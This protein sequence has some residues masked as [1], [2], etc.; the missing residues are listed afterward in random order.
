MF[1]CDRMLGCDIPTHDDR[2]CDWCGEPSETDICPTCQR[3]YEDEAD[4]HSIEF[5]GSSLAF[6]G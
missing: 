3:R 5:S 6:R 2:C 4:S 1:P